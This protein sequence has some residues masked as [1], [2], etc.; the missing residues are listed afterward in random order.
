MSV[1]WRYRL[2]G[3]AEVVLFGA[4]VA[5]AL[6][7]VVLAAIGLATVIGWDGPS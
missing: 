3:A 1:R 4:V 5:L 7:V 6:V 2:D